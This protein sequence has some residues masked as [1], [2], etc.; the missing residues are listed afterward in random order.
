MTVAELNQVNNIGPRKRIAT[1]QALLVALS[2]GEINP[3]LPQLPAPVTV[4]QAFKGARYARGS[5]AQRKTTA[6]PGAR[7]VAS[8][9]KGKVA[10]KTV[11][12]KAP[13]KA[14]THKV[15]LAQPRKK[16]QNN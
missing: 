15:A 1:G 12:T 7:N 10:G 13:T 5:A 3:Q 11:A 6:R 8:I 4:T 2:S 16:Q 9:Q 14:A